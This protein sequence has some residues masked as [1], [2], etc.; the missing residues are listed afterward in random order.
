[1]RFEA[2]AVRLGYS[3]HKDNRLAT[4]EA[5]INQQRLKAA[6]NKALGAAPPDEKPAPKPGGKP[7]PA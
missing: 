1:M 2:A 7:G 4:A 5:D 6:A 3:V